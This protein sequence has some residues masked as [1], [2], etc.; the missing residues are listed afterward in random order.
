M[1]MGETGDGAGRARAIRSVR[2]WDLPTRLF[3][4]LLAALVAVNIYTGTVGG[5]AEMDWHLWSG[6]AIL[7]LVGFR[8]VWGLIGSRRSRFA[9]F[10]RGPT[11]V[12]AYARGLVAGRATASLGHNPMG[13]WSALAM[14]ACLAVQGVTGLYSSDDIF[15]EGPL[16][17]TVSGD[18]VKLMTAIHHWNSNVLF[19]LI[20]LHLAAVLGYLVVKRDNLIGPMLTGRKRV[21]PG[22]PEDDAPFVNPLWA[23]V[24]LAAA[25]GL[26]WWATG[27]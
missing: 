14:L 23:A 18:T 17:A 11:A 20:G 21:P 22:L 15:T 1:A 25:A 19:V 13:A 7:A 4:W 24:A 5:L 9:D 8:V 3:H 6:Q 26:V 10:V 12:A 2:V 16:A 27:G